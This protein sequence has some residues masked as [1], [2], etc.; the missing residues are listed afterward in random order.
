MPFYFGDLNKKGPPFRELPKFSRE[1]SSEQDYL[2]ETPKVKK[3]RFGSLRHFGQPQRPA[4]ILLY[5]WLPK[6]RIVLRLRRGP[7]VKS[8]SGVL[9]T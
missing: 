7:E 3:L 9:P 6:V 2:L 8:S 4:C 1:K 5:R